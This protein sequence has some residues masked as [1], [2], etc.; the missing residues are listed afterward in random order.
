MVLLRDPRVLGGNE[1]DG[2]QAKC[3]GSV[4]AG[5]RDGEICACY[6]ESDCAP[7]GNGGDTELVRLNVSHGS[8]H[9]YEHAFA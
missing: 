9:G 6:G 4:R 1:G 2:E 7:G 3:E 5:G 8:T